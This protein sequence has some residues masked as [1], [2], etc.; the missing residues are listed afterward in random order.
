MT[1]IMIENPR[2]PRRRVL[3]I[4]A[5]S[6]VALAIATWFASPYK[7]LYNPSDSAPHG[8]YTL[9]P[10]HRLKVGQ[11]VLAN[12][13][14]PTAAFAS[15]RGYLPM[16]VPVLKPIAATEGHR[17]CT[18]GRAILIRNR[19]VAVARDTD[20]AGRALPQWHGCRDLQADEVFLLSSHSPA[21]FDSRYFGPLQ[22]TQIIGRVIPLWTW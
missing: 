12:L 7:L 10:A 9:I 3:W 20:G 13:P 22:T 17:V 1:W 16:S 4:T 5:T 19:F 11:R 14:M 2:T 8:W 6:V 18:D 15:A 21:S